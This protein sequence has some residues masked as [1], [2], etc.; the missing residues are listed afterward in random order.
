MSKD[1][2][3]VAS[4]LE[5][6]GRHGDT[7]VAHINPREAL[8]LAL[9]GGAATK[10]PK[11]GLLEFYDSSYDGGGAGN[12]DNSIGGGFA[13]DATGG[14]SRPPANNLPTPSRAAIK[15]T[16]RRKLLEARP[17]AKNTQMP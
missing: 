13:S 5:D 11:T 10:N 6:H 9:M 16:F 8:M 3:R 14:G 4:K 7:L 1:I 12:Q 2:R 15:S 17:P